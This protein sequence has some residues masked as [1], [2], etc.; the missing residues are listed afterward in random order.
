MIVEQG[1]NA[2]SMA[3]KYDMDALLTPSFFKSINL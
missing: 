2:Q 3:M 1:K